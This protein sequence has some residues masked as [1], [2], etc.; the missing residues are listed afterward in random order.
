M[1]RKEKIGNKLIIESDED[2]YV[3]ITDNKIYLHH[4]EVNGCY[5][6]LLFDNYI[7]WDEKFA[8]IFNNKFD[9]LSYI[10]EKKIIKY[11]MCR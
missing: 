8:I 3:L 10:K 7:Y 9:C 5:E 11:G 1:I 4:Q 6:F 2:I